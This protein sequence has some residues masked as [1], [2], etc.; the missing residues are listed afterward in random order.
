M[1]YRES[2]GF[3]AETAKPSL[4]GQGAPGIVRVGGGWARYS[5]ARGVKESQFG[6]L[7]SPSTGAELWGGT[8]PPP[9]GHKGGWNIGSSDLSPLLDPLGE[10]GAAV[11]HPTRN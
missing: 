1:C 7:S 5:W 4:V 9:G 11:V 2:H 6:G 8:A 10:G 3:V